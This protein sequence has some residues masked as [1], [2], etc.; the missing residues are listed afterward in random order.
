MGEGTL[1]LLL[2]QAGPQTI[3]SG[4]IQAL[5]VYELAEM[6]KTEERWERD[7]PTGISG[8]NFVL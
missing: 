5:L 1:V 8:L 7:T 4:L 3:C 2:S 6:G